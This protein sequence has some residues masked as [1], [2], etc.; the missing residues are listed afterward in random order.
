MRDE[1]KLL[2]QEI[3]D[4]F[5]VFP[6]FVVMKYGKLT[7]NAANDFRREVRKL[8]GD[9]KIVRK[10]VLLKAADDAGINLD[11]ATLEGHV[12][13]VFL[14]GEPVDVTKFVFKFSQDQAKVLEVLG[15]RFEGTLYSGADVEKLSKLPGKDEMR[16]QFLSLLEAPMS[17]TLVVMEALLTSVPHCLENKCKKENGETDGES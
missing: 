5:E 13:V 17:Q 10:R 3:I 14:G 9:V 6:S 1:K 4:K 7:A 8:G 12:G 16:A 2:K 11:F 15:G